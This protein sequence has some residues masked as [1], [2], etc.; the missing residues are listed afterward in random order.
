MPMRSLTWRCHTQAHMCYCSLQ[1]E[2]R[3]AFLAKAST[4]ELIKQA[5]AEPW[6]R[7]GPEIPTS[8]ALSSKKT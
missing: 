3:N 8:T 7:F 6:R 5:V 4:P 1:A 2:S